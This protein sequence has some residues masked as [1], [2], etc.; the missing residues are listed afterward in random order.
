MLIPD[1]EE[2]KTICLDGSNRDTIGKENIHYPAI[3]AAFIADINYKTDALMPSVVPK[4]IEE[5]YIEPAK[6]TVW[7]NYGTFIRKQIRDM[8]KDIKTRKSKFSEVMNPAKIILAIRQR[9]G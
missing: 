9:P 5:V 4:P 7:D 2:I 3:S 8:S 1:E 6:I